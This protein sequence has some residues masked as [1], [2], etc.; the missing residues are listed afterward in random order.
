MTTLSSEEFNALGSK[1]A[2]TFTI[3]VTTAAC[4]VAQI[5]VACRHYAN[6]GASRDIVEKWAKEVQRSLSLISP[7][8]AQILELGWDPDLDTKT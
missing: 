8:L 1:I 2:G 7:E 6:F 5:Q 4:L 3:D